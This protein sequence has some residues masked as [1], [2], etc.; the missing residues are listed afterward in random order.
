MGNKIVLIECCN[1]VDYPTGGQLTF[2]KQMIKCFG[3]DLILIGLATD[4][5]PIGKW[6][7]KTIDGI[8]YDYFPYIYLQKSSKKPIIP[9]RLRN[10]LALKKYKR[11]IESINLFNV[12]V[13]SPDTL[14]AAIKY[15]KNVN[16]CYRFAGTENPLAISRYRWARLI[17][18]LYDKYFLPKLSWMNLILAAADSNAINDLISRSNG[19]LKKNKVIQFPTR[20]DT[21]LFHFKDKLV[22]RETLSV[23]RT[24]LIIVTSGRLAWFK[25]WKFMIDSFNIFRNNHSEAHLYFLGNGE[26]F[27]KIMDYLAFLKLKDCVHLIGYKPENVIGEYLNAADLFIMGSFK[28]GWSTSLIEAVV[29]GTPACV[30]NFSSAKDIITDGIN[31]YVAQEHNEMLFAELMHKCLQIDRNK[32][33]REEDVEKYSIS[34]LKEELLKLWPLV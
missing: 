29:C 32:L 5:T 17:S 11:E 23:P 31:G 4:D 9:L 20:V 6:T 33:P 30:T 8:T 3:N 14:F 1:F 25:G 10:Y 12:I 19:T 22:A 21:T 13:Q 26:D 27:S 18:F 2:A 24:Q 34:H 16:I 15:L 7:K 28:E